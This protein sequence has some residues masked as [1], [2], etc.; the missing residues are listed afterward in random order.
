ME[1]HYNYLYS[2]IHS[3]HIKD[4]DLLLRVLSKDDLP[5]KVLRAYFSSDSIDDSIVEQAFVKFNNLLLNEDMLF[6]LNETTYAYNII[7]K[8]FKLNYIDRFVE[9]KSDDDLKIYL[10]HFDKSFIENSNLNQ[11]N[12]SRVLKLLFS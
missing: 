1:I 6:N 3:D 8:L 12:K 9:S 4:S 5:I 2:S 11:K 10:K 7:E